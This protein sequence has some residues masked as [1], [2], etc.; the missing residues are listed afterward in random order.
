MIVLAMDHVEESV[1]TAKYLRRTYPHVKILARAR[2]RFHACRLMD[3]GVEH[4]WRET[5]LS[6]LEMAYETLV[7]V[8]IHPHTARHG[9]N[10]FR[11]YD[12]DL[13]RRQQAF[14]TDEQQLIAS[15]RAALAE[16]ENLF[17]NDQIDQHQIHADTHQQQE[18]QIDHA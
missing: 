8:G 12:E 5:L 15:N 9:V 7:S 17:D 2:D 4:I 18:N 3:L 11:Q 14:Y 6:S 16:L 13:L 10:T 1:S